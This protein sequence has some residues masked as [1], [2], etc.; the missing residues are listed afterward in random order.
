MS[1]LENRIMDIEGTIISEVERCKTKIARYDH[2][3][4]EEANRVAAITSPRAHMPAAMPPPTPLHHMGRRLESSHAG[5]H[6]GE[7]DF[8]RAGSDPVDMEHQVMT[9]DP[10]P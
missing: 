2:F 4:A 6:D 9:L 5:S 8:K 10:R 1:V 7:L 3:I